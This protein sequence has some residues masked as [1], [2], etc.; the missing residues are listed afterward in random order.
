[1]IL[2]SRFA[3]ICLRSTRIGATQS[4]LLHRARLTRL[5]LS[6]PPL[7]FKASH[8]GWRPGRL[9]QRPLVIPRCASAPWPSLCS[10]N[11]S[12]CL[13]ATGTVQN[14]HQC[15]RCLWYSERQPKI[16]NTQAVIFKLRINAIARNYLNNLILAQTA[17]FIMLFSNYLCNSFQAY[18]HNIAPNANAK[19]FHRVRCC[20]LRW[21]FCFLP[22]ANRTE[23]ENRDLQRP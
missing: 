21:T 20:P 9:H 3:S 8:V 2:V 1:M 6:R 5:S 14:L 7:C 23:Y 18:V 4:H 16:E 11:I 10:P 19:T 15:I 22:A 13:H 17:V 12:H